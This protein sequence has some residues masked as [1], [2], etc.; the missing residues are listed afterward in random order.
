MT[1][2]VLNVGGLRPGATIQVQVPGGTLHALTWGSGDEV[3]LSYD[4]LRRKLRRGE[5]PVLLLERRRHEASGFHQRQQGP[6]LPRA[7][8]AGERCVLL[9]IRP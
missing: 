1:D 8:L 2:Q 3:V 7:R 9:K 4:C 6:E 5:Q